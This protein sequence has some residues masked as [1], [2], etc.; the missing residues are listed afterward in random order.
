MMDGIT[1]RSN[2]SL[3]LTPNYENMNRWLGITILKT[4][5]SILKIHIFSVAYKIIIK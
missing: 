4:A 3:K 2:I 1:Y 5:Q